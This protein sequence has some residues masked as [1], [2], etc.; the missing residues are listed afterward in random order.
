MVTF[1]EGL[2]KATGPATAIQYD[3][4]CNYI[5]TTHFGGIWAA[6]FTDVTVAVIGLNPL[7]EGEEGDAFLSQSG[8]D[9]TDLDL[10]RAHVLYL[11]KLMRNVT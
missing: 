5:D 11:K 4:G 2:I 9:K 3:L 7:L 6:G 8:G 10:P 1:V